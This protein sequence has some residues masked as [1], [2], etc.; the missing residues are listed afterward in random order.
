[1]DAIL[2]ENEDAKKE[3]LIHLMTTD[4]ALSMNPFMISNIHQFVLLYFSVVCSFDELWGV[5]GN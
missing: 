2:F 4:G 5:F 3:K 1:M